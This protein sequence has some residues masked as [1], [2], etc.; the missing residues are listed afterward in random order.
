MQITSKIIN[1]RGTI[2]LYYSHL[3]KEYRKS[4]GIATTDRDFKS[5]VKLH[6]IYIMEQK[7]VVD[8][9]I[10]KGIN[11]QVPNIVDYINDNIAVKRESAK[12][13]VEQE[14]QTVFEAFQLFHETEIKGKGQRQLTTIEDYTTFKNDLERYNSTITVKQIGS[15]FCQHLI[16]HYYKKG[17]STH[18]ITKK[19]IIAF[20]FLKYLFTKGMLNSDVYNQ[21]LEVK[22]KEIKPT[23][24]SFTK[25]EVKALMNYEPTTKCFEQIKDLTLFSI[26][27]GVNYSDLQNI[28]KSMIKNNMLTYNRQ[29]TKVLSQVPLTDLANELLIKYNYNF[30]LLSNQ[31][32][33]DYL[34]DMLSEIEI[35]REKESYVD[36]AT[37][38]NISDFK[39]NLVSHKTCRKTFITFAILKNVP[40]SELIKCVGHSDLKMIKNYMDT[41]HRNVDGLTNTLNNFFD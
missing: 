39:Y 22:V 38:N 17:L 6:N 12:K 31:K 16:D 19:R 21:N 20:K 26:S 15:D 35:F 5:A 37:G 10:Q 27:T 8:S 4:L 36:T 34:K 24:I 41:M 25:E 1:R 11:L 29:K 9:L 7:E 32:F 23:I 18:S 2:H 28:T 30:N 14:R 3:K 13:A 33:N 40:L